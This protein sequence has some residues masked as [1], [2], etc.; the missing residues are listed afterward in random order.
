MVSRKLP[1]P[2]AKKITQWA[3]EKER[4]REEECVRE[5]ERESDSHTNIYSL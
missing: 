4:Y 1:K 2:V 5:R 3:G